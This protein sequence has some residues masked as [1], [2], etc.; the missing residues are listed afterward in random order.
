MKKKLIVI[1][2]GTASITKKNGEPD[3]EIIEKIATQVTALHQNFRIILVSSGAV[4]AG[5]HFIKKYDGSISQKKAAAAVGNPILL[6]LY[7][8]AFEKYGIYVAQ[9]LLERQH[10]A[11]RTQFLQLKETYQTLWKS[12]IIPI[13]N[14]NDVVSSRELKFSDND[15]LATLLAGGFEASYLLLCTSSGGLLDKNGEL[16]TKVEKIDEQVLALVNKSKSSLGLGGMASKLTFTQLATKMGIKT[17][18]FG[19]KKENS[20]LEAINENS[21]TVFSPSTNKLSAKN[22]WLASGGISVGKVQIDE[23][24][25]NAILN[26]KSLLAVGI[27]NCIGEFEMG[28][29]LEIT[30]ENQN[31]LAIGRTKVSSKELEKNLKTQNLVLIHADNLVII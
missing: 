9:S 8:D 3:L 16:V 1:K 11:N 4:G 7:A 22:K 30:D 6:K 23:G 2:F 13:A 26:R 29:I 12:N 20:I 28:D 25:K 18:I 31:T 14:E 21:G 19:M 24:A 5:K 15:E 10:F 27:L 17:I